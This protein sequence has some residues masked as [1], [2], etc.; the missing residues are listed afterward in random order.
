MVLDINYRLVKVFKSEAEA[1]A[2]VA[3]ANGTDSATV[4]EETDSRAAML[5]EY[6]E[7]MIRHSRPTE[8]PDAVD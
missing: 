3:R 1:V 8:P 6:R 7:N 5:D 4:L 2:F